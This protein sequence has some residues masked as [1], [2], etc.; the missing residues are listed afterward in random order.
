M[1][2]LTTEEWA[3]QAREYAADFTQAAYEDRFRTAV[4]SGL[5]RY[6]TGV[7]KY[8]ANKRLQ[9]LDDVP[10]AVGKRVDEP[11]IYRTFREGFAPPKGESRAA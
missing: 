11:A 5:A 6:P 10:G 3:R 8:L 1:G 2:L 7:A 9:L 4:F